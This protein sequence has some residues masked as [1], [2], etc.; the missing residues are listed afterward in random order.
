MN[1]DRKEMAFRVGLLAAAAVLLLA[2]ASLNASGRETAGLVGAA[3]S[4]VLA[5]AAGVLYRRWRLAVPI[6]AMAIVLSLV[7][8]QFNPHQGDL[9]LQLAG[10]VLLALGGAMGAMAYGRFGEA[11][12]Q[13]MDA[14][15]AL[16]QHLEQK[17]RAFLAA[18][19]DVE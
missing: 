9:V 7:I 17:H 2:G 12:Q 1:S 15:I 4:G 16:H 18:T 6:G 3:V 11:L 13:Q 10:L 8:A 5:L 19:S 14:V